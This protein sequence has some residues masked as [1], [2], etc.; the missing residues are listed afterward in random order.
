MALI[1]NGKGGLYGFK[2]MTV[3]SFTHGLVESIRGTQRVWSGFAGA[4][5]SA[6]SVFLLEILCACVKIS[7]LLEVTALTFSILGLASV[8]L[9]S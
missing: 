3:L 7:S 4:D 8:L 2:G 1:G 5:S 6:F 9:G